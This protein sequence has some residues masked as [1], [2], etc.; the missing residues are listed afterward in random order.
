MEKAGTMRLELLKRDN[1]GKMSSIITPHYTF[2][3][4]TMKKHILVMMLQLII[5][6][7]L[8]CTSEEALPTSPQAEGWSFFNN[9]V[10]RAFAAAGSEFKAA[11]KDMIHNN[12]DLT[13]AQIDINKSI[14]SISESKEHL[15]A[16]LT[17]LRNN[18]G[19]TISAST[20]A[21]YADMVLKNNL[22]TT[23]EQIPDNPH[24][25]FHNIS[26]STKDIDIIRSYIRKIIA[27]HNQDYEPVK[28]SWES[29]KATY[30]KLDAQINSSNTLARYTFPAVR[31]LGY[32]TVFTA[33]PYLGNT[34]YTKLLSHFFA[35]NQV[36]HA[37]IMQRII[38]LEEEC[39]ALMA[40][41]ETHK[42]ALQDNKNTEQEHKLKA[43]IKRLEATLITLRQEVDTLTAHMSLPQEPAAWR[44]YMGMG[45]R[46]S[47]I[48]LTTY[49]FYTI[50]KKIDENY[51]SLP[52]DATVD[53]ELLRTQLQQLLEIKKAYEAQESIHADLDKILTS[54]DAG[55]AH[56]ISNLR[57]AIEGILSHHKHIADS[58]EHLE[59]MKLKTITQIF[60]F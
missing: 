12:E 52:D 23:P 43:N 14:A 36:D 17:S 9:P 24:D 40:K 35:K 25:M 44:T 19:I 13:K 53:K 37:D 6:S 42:K 48:A 57:A 21:K 20:W 4:M 47:M 33:G 55:L 51:L 34:V 54:D 16:T 18:H 26:A 28:N 2:G 32:A 56:A 39:D 50:F 49:L 41:L 59:E 60:N 11:L 46:V 27:L 45:V 5:T 1:C 10:T 29:H 30:Q 7:S 31:W 3:L 15:S 58:K 8:S 38:T 22:A